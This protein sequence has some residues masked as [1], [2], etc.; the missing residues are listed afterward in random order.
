MQLCLA[1]KLLLSRPQHLAL[2]SIFRPR[3][4]KSLVA[5]TALGSFA[6]MSTENGSAG[7]TVAPYRITLEDITRST[8]SGHDYGGT[9]FAMK[10]SRFHRW[11]FVI[12][13][14]TYDDDTAWER[15]LEVLR[16]ARLRS[17]VWAGDDLLLEQYMDWPVISDKATLDGASKAEVRKHFKS[18]CAARSEE[19]DGH[20]AT[21]SRTK[22]LPRFKYCVYVDRKCL[23]TL[24]RLPANYRETRRQPTDVVAVLIDGAFDERTPG[25]DVG[26]YPDIEGC[27]ER[28]VGWRYETIEMLAATYDECHNYD[29]GH[30]DYKRPPLISPFG[31]ESMP[32]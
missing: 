25:E 19:R 31:F 29:L 18:W 8:W 7:S 22:H 26:W 21:G 28:Y 1:S 32:V 11:G 12:Y 6:K 23:D 20:G 13:R 10:W 5:S 14:T 3:G 24:A 27:T 2:V 30:F 17:L 9:A 15:Y 4:S 16:L